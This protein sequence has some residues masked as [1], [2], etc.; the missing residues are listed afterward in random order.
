MHISHPYCFYWPPSLR[1]TPRTKSRRP[2]PNGRQPRRRPQAVAEI[3]P[4]P[5][6]RDLTPGNAATLYYRAMAS[7]T[8]TPRC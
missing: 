8:K 5:D 4:H 3:P 6:R 2:D 1:P 7:F